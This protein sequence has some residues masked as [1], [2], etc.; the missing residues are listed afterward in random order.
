[1]IVD[2]FQ[3]NKTKYNWF[4]LTLAIAFLAGPAIFSACNP[5]KPAA[6]HLKW[7]FDDLSLRSSLSEDTVRH[8]DSQ[9]FVLQYVMQ[10]VVFHE[11]TKSGNGSLMA[12]DPVLTNSY[13]QTA[14]SLHLEASDSIGSAIPSGTNLNA[15]FEFA[16]FSDTPEW[17]SDPLGILTPELGNLRMIRLVKRPG[18]L[19]YLKVKAVLFLHDGNR[20]ESK[21]LVL[22]F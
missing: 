4:V 10:R 5:C 21:N 19:A 13:L 12:C 17:L 18:R 8:S 6:S 1:M 11:N 15:F 16:L 20:L 22:T 2:P 9:A 7:K 3:I 14:D